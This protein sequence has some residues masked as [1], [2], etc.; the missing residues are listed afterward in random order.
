MKKHLGLFFTRYVSLGTWSQVGNLTRELALYKRLVENG[1]DVSFVTYGDASDLQ[2]SGV[3][4]GIRVICNETGLSPQEYEVQMFKIHENKFRDFSAIKTNQ[5]YGA[6][7]ALN[8]AQ[9]LAKPF[10]ARCGYLWSVNTTKEN[11]AKSEKSLE[12]H[13]VERIVFS[14]ADV[15]CLTTEEMKRNVL[16][17]LPGCEGKIRIIPNYVETDR[18]KPL[19]CRKEPKQ[20]IFVGRIAPEKNLVSL[21][22]AI[23][24]LQVR[25]ILIG[26]GPQ[27]E[28]LAVRFS[29]LSDKVIWM[30]NLPNS[31]LPFHLNSSSIFVLPSLYEGHPKALI[32]AMACQIPVIGCDSPGIREIIQ[33]HKN[34]ILCGHGHEEISRSIQYLLD[35]QDL[36]NS[37]ARNARNYVVD[38]YA[39]DKIVEME[40][41][42]LDELLN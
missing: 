29:D 22:E 27:R 37:L 14:E 19:K 12:A 7:L 2:Y 23:R 36:A 31:E 32:E 41:D 33:N 5:M 17:R 8:V 35:H 4:G 34:G 21:F 39:L 24:N 3:L 10:V 1:F 30:G 15:I 18:F 40:C 13:R 6:D 25:L 42:M 9:K 20:I 16:G 28:E 26:D 38:H 11:G